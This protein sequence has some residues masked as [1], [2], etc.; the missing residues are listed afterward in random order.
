WIHSLY[1]SALRLI[2]GISTAGVFIVIESWLLMQSGPA[3]RGAA[4][5]LYLAVFYAALSGGQF[6]L[7]LS[8]PKGFSPFGI[9]AAFLLCSMLPI[10]T[11]K[12]EKPKLEKEAVRLKFTELVKLSPLGFVGG[13]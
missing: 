9:T 8:D 13:I 10:A 2:G 11:S 4:L 12:K 5:S 6:L 3:L 1:W 7:N